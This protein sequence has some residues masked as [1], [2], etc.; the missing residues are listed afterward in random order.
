[1]INS[2]KYIALVFLVNLWQPSFGQIFSESANAVGINH[3]VVLNVLMGGG[4]AVIDYNNDSFE[5]LYFTGGDAGDQLFMNNGDA[6]FTDVSDQAGISFTASINTLGVAAGDIDNDG[7]RDLFVTTGMGLP[8]ILLYNNGDGTFTNIAAVAGITQD[9][10]SMSVSFGDVN[11]DGFL[12]IYVANFLIQQR[13]IYDTQ[14]KIIGFDPLCSANYLYINQG[15]KTFIQQSAQYGVGNEGCGLATSFSD[16][17][18]DDDVDIMIAN[19]FGPWHISTTLYD[20][21][22]P[23]NFYVDK[24]NSTNFSSDIYGMGIAIGDI[25]NDLY[26]DYYMT[27]LGRNVLY[28]ANGD[29]T[30]SDLTTAAGVEDDS[31]NN[32]LATGWGA[33]FLD[34]DN[35]GLQDL[36]V[37]NGQIPSGLDFTRNALQ[38]PNRLFKN[39]GNNKFSDVT[40]QAGVGNDLMGRGAAYVDFDNDGDLDIISC[41]I[42]RDPNSFVPIDFYK[43]NSVNNNNWFKIKLKGTHANADAIGAQVIVYLDDGQK[44]IREID[45]GSSHLSHNSIIAHFGL[46]TNASIDSLN[47]IW[48]GGNRH[49]VYNAKPD[50]IYSVVE[51][52]SDVQVTTVNCNT[53][54]TIITLLNTHPNSSYAL[55]NLSN[56]TVVGDEQI[57]SG[58]P[59]QFSTGTV[60]KDTYYQ[61]RVNQGGIIFSLDSQIFKRVSPVKAIIQVND[62]TLESSNG[63]SYKWFYEGNEVSTDKVIQIENSGKYWVEV[64]DLYGCVSVSDPVDVLLTGLNEIAKS[65]L[66]VFPNPSTG[67]FEV[68]DNHITSKSIAVI[69]NSLGQIVVPQEIAFRKNKIKIDLSNKKDGIYLMKLYFAGEVTTVTLVK[70]F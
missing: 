51:D 6:T 13:F 60:A 27:N 22:Y 45:G 38:N 18:N 70:T 29:A 16:Y 2:S 44:M 20:N 28:H 66:R 69:Y 17:N 4:V 10:W 58:V 8:N 11:N 15:D 40:D 46:G 68:E 64:T 47:I 61:M 65:K 3:Q 23:D 52:V 19:D 43:N 59:L 34:Y 55:Y 49:M 56:G 41:V 36:F 7:Y 67:I 33:M 26:K 5:D 35:D 50:T 32:E 57:A 54:P 31:V 63:N 42:H 12:D 9:D 53:D 62:Q 21:N 37:N 39:I 25:D 48:P 14:N 30:F 24:T 1:M